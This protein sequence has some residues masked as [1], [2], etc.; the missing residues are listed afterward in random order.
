MDTKQTTELWRAE[1]IQY[2][3][4]EGYRE[5]ASCLTMVPEEQREGILAAIVGFLMFY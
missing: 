3:Y 4:P 5:A 2:T 1:K